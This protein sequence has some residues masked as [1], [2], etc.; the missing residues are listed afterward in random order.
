MEL[1]VALLHS[2]LGNQHPSSVPVPVPLTRFSI[3]S[4]SGKEDDV[5]SIK[6]NQGGKCEFIPH[7]LRGSLMTFSQ[8]SPMVRTK[9]QPTLIATWVRVGVRVSVLSHSLTPIFLDLLTNHPYPLRSLSPPTSHSVC[10]DRLQRLSA[11]L[12]VLIRLCGHM[13][14]TGLSLCEG[15]VTIIAPAEVRQ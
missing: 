10:R 2:P 13:Q 8:I 3:P 1:M 14:K 7:Q 11:A 9:L 15:F 6:S 4:S 12:P 5:D